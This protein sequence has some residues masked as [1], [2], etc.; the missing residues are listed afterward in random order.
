MPTS[1]IIRWNTTTHI[2]E[3][4]TDFGTSYS[5]L[6]LDAAII[7]AGTI[8]AA[9]LGG[10]SPDSTK[11]LGGDQTFRQVADAQVASAAAIAW[12]K[13]SKTS[14]SLL[15]LATRSAADLSS[16]LL[17]LARGGVNADLSGTGGAG[18]FLKQVS[19]GAAITV[20]QPATTDIS[21]ITSGTFTPAD[22]SGASLSFTVNYATYIKVGKLVFIDFRLVYPTTASGATATISGFPFTAGGNTYYPIAGITQGT[23]HTGFV[24]INGSATTALIYDQTASAPYL[25]SGLSGLTLSFNGV[26][27]TP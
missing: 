6:T 23:S 8:A 14:S 10:G 12:S 5:A 24:L 19:A 15:D 20:V 27:H 16:G 7:N 25:N 26:Y 4:S 3:I 13:I 21:D 9:R 11:F 17:A 18:K 22:G 2:W 1:R